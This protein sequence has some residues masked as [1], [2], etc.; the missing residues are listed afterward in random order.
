MKKDENIENELENLSPLLSKMRKEQKGS[1]YT[2]PP[3]YFKNLTEEMMQKVEPTRS[4]KVRKVLWEELFTMID[5]FIQ[6]KFVMGLATIVL[7][8]MG[9]IYFVNIP[10][11]EN[12]VAIVEPSLADLEQ[13][14]IAHADELSEEMLVE[15][16]VGDA[17]IEFELNVEEQTFDYY[18]EEVLED[19]QEEDLEQFL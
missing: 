9:G 16:K 15:Y 2:V 10:T 11:S 18:F 3:I 6:P 13:Y 5:N 8:I 17:A 12:D 7:L 19:L 14:L 4:P 1:G